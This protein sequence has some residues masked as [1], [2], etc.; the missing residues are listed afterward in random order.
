MQRVFYQIGQISDIGVHPIGLPN[1]IPEGLGEFN[2][3]ES[4]P[5]PIYINMVAMDSSIKLSLVCEVLRRLQS[6]FPAA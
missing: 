5:N 4:G 6:Y 1:T 2:S 3:K